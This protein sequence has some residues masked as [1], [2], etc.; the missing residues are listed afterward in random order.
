V[1]D[2]DIKL[3]ERFKFRHGSIYVE[4]RNRGYALVHGQT[5]VPIARLRP[6]LRDNFVEIFY[7]SLGKQRW[8]PFGPFGSTAVSVDEAL[9]IIDGNDIFWA[10]I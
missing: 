2:D 6:Y 7:W 3:I 9:R 4:R 1:T 10:V 5:G 8:A